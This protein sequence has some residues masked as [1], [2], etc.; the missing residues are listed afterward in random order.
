MSSAS[1]MLQ[2]LSE[3]MASSDKGA[4]ARR[5]RAQASLRDGREVTWGTWR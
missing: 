5:S 4:A 1:A 3:K 2:T